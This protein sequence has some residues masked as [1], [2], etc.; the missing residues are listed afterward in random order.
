MLSQSF[1]V[2]NTLVNGSTMWLD[3]C[4]YYS[5][6]RLNMKMPNLS[7]QRQSSKYLPK[8]VY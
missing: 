4:G 7:R 8:K 6:V 3:G 2:V 5:E 1:R